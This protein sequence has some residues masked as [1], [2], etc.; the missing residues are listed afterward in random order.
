MYSALP[1]RHLL[2]QVGLN[3]LR[4][5]LEEGAG[6]AAAAGAGRDL[7]REAANAHRLQNLLRDPDFF[8]AVAARRGRQRNANRVADAFLQQHAHRG[9]RCHHALRAHPGFRES[10]M[11]RIFAACGQ[12]AIDINQIL[13][14]AD[15]R[16]ENDLVGAQAELLRQLRRIQRA[17]HHGFHGDFAGVFG[18]VEPRILVHHAG[19]Q[20][21]VERSPV[22]A[23]AHRLFILHR[24]FDHGAEIGV[25]RTSNAGVAGIDAVLGQ[26]ARALG[27]LGQQQMP[28]VVEVAD[29]G[30]ADALLVELLDDV[31]NGRRSLVIVHGNAYQF[32]SGAGQ[33]RHLL[34][35]RGD[36]RRV[37]IGHGLHHN[38]CI[39]AYA[40]TA[41]DGRNGLSALNIGHMGSSILSR[42]KRAPSHGWRS[43]FSAAIK[44]R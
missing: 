33:R 28:V 9:A 22:H 17:H 42:G 40:H 11:Q 36:V 23:D 3:L 2:A 44:C 32:R 10:K 13:H 5:L 35:G 27:I 20:R 16:A 1:R 39:R 31:G 21:L 18:L 14:A 43:A 37:G 4:H 26:I 15:L 38:R 34:H 24:D 7:R 12:R 29:D 6:G 30:H 8:G 25:A 41:D 19:Q